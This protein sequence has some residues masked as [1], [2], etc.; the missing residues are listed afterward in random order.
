MVFWRRVN[1]LCQALAQFAVIAKGIEGRGRNCVDRVR[2]DQFF[3][4]KHVAII[5]VFGAGAGPEHALR[6]RALLGECLPAWAAENFLIFLVGQLSVGN[7]DL[8]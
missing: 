2:A 5:G 8:A 6:L 4:V 7:G 1:V 3:H